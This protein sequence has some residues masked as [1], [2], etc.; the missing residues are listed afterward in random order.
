MLALLT[1][2]W[3]ILAGVVVQANQTAHR[4]HLSPHATVGLEAQQ[5]ISRAIGERAGAYRGVGKCV[6]ASQPAAEVHPD[7]PA[8]SRPLSLLLARGQ[9]CATVKKR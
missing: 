7:I 2:G 5:A 6:R 8:A 9:P 3:D 4:S 1:Y